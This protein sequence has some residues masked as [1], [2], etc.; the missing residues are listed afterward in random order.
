MQNSFFRITANTII[1]ISRIDSNRRLL[2][3]KICAL[4]VNT[5]NEKHLNYKKGLLLTLN[6]KDYE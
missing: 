3:R 6:K 5:N 2:M 1:L 4:F